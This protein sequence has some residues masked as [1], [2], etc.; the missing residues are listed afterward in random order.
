M[1][2]LDITGFIGRFHPLIVHL[3]IG[4]IIAA[5]LIEWRM[6]NER[7]QNVISYLWILSAITAG[8]ASL[9]GWFLANE[10]SYANW[11]LF[12]HRWLGI[13][14][15]VVSLYAWYA[16]RGGSTS[17]LKK[18]ATNVI[19]IVMLAITGH[20]GGNM[21]HGSDYL[22][23]YAPSPI[24]KLLGYGKSGNNLPQF[25]DPDSVNTYR[26]IIFP[27]FEKKCISCHNDKV[28][29]G[30]LNMA[31]IDSIKV[32]GD[33]GPVIV[34]G[35]IN[36]ELLRRVTLPVT[37]AKFMPT[38]GTHMTYHEVRL[39]EWWI[40]QGAEYQTSISAMTANPSI[41]SILMSLYGLDL[42][43]RPWIEKTKVLLPDSSVMTSI[44]S[45][46][47]KLN[48]IANNNGWVE[49][50]NHIGSEVTE[51]Q[52]RSLSVASDQITW[53]QLP[54]SGLTDEMI[55]HINDLSNLTKLKIQGNPITST[56]LAQ[57]ENLSNLETLN[58]TNTK[59]DN[60]I[61]DLLSKMPKL[62][63]LYLWQ[64]EATAEAIE[65][66]RTRFPDIDIVGGIE[67]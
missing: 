41:Q 1:L 7:Y 12:A 50:S 49:V 17:P 51:E 44:R 23:E 28:Q 52:L 14:I 24:Q 61:F 39:L 40:T 56:G 53:L 13:L 66:A 42:T 31:S 38:S 9:C 2:L 18:K 8:V 60:S 62:K 67:N 33:G 3:P 45:T 34:S 57:L 35:D 22:L 55:I 30:G 48:V 58:L 63:S 54:N 37:S 5:V 15:A 19:A 32:G 27:T 65:D 4:F 29:N 10:G 6:K 59:I 11:T 36:S 25:A 26:D 47:I 46:G 43:P 20:L 64:S 16:R 21:T